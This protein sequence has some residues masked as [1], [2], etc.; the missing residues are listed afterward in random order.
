MFPS[1]EDFG[2]AGLF[3]FMV[4]AKNRELPVEFR[5]VQPG[6]EVLS[7]RTDSGDQPL[8]TSRGLHWNI[9]RRLLSKRMLRRLDLGKIFLVTISP[10]TVSSTTFS[11]RAPAT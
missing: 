10:K 4:Y 2:A 7:Y 5:V 3:S 11:T 8:R 6:K 1:H 9:E